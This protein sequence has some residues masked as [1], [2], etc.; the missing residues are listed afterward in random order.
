[1]DIQNTIK[2]L[3]KA[4]YKNLCGF[5]IFKVTF[6]INIINEC[7]RT[8][9]FCPYHSKKLADNYHTNW[10]KKQPLQ[11]DY[12]KFKKFLNKIGIFRKLIKRIAITGK[13]E[14]FLHKDLYKFCA[15]CNSYK[16]PFSITTN[17]DYVI[18]QADIF[19]N[20][21]KLK[22]LAGIRISIYELKRWDTLKLIKH[23]KLTFFN[24]TGKRIDGIKKG[25]LTANYGIKHKRALKDFNIST[26]CKAPFH[27]LTINTDGSIVPCYSYDEIANISNPFLN[28]WNGKKV[29]KYRDAAVNGRD[30]KY[31]DCINC[32]IGIK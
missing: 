27:F 9:S 19:F 8:C 24:Q 4:I 28:I 31:S 11:L 10:Y 23:D 6:A 15:L 22:Y 16:I 1:M 29:R 7:N 21:L 26:F 14:P 3:K 12:I 13:G 30:I 5:T 2:E 18:P 20:I 32:G 17:G 25:Y